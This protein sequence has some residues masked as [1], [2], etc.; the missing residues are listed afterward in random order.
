M[1]F[2]LKEKVYVTYV[3]S[4]IVYGSEMWAMMAEQSGRLEHMEMRMVRWMCG[5]SLR[6]RVRIES[7][8]DTVKPK[9]LRWLG[10]VLQKND[11][12]WLKKIMSFEVEDKRGQRRPMEPGGGKEHERVWVEKGRCKGRGEVEEV[13]V[14]SRRPTS[15]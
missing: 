6:D 1:S 14:Q 2:K 12:D 13:A 4:A 5:A 10:H 3:R 11:D 7:V 9:R 8:S 15:A